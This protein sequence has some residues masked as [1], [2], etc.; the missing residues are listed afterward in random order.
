MR[1][2]LD[3]LDKIRNKLRG[4]DLLLLLDYDGTLSPIARTPDKSVFPDGMKFALKELAGDPACRIAVIS[5]R[6]LDNIKK[7]VGLKDIIY[8]GNHGL[9]IEGP[10]LKYKAAVSPLYKKAIGEIRDSLAARFSKIKGAIIED[11]GLSLSLHY[12][13]VRK[14]EIP[15]LKNIF[16]RTIT[17]HPAKEKIMVKP[18]KMVFDIRPASGLDK[19]KVA[20]WLLARESFRR[21]GRKVIPIYIGDDLTDEDAFKALK[22]IGIT[23]CVCKGRKSSAQYYLKGAGQ[24]RSFLKELAGILKNRGK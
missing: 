14:N 18:G 20:L 15:P 7:K 4:R 17:D 6:Q 8:S 13:L 11:K 10:R 22:N 9:E 16:R 3:D 21:R 19:G 5:G 1:H 12:R 23:I 2:L 24:V